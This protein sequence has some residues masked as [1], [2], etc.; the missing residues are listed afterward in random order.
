V[1]TLAEAARANG[2]RKTALILVGDFL[3]AAYERSRLYD[4]AFE[5]EYR[6]KTDINT[7]IK[8]I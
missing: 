1:G 3:G 6:K 8:Q 4:P 2:I 7:N 5:T